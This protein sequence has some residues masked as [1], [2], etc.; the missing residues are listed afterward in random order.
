MKNLLAIEAST[1][2]CSVAL[3]CNGQVQVLNSDEP[4]AHTASL[5]AFVD[6]LLQSSAVAVPQLDAVVFSAGPGSFTGI[7]LA[8]AVAKSLAYAAGLPVIGIS[9]L[10]AMAQAFY[11]QQA[12][13]AT[14]RII[15]D[16][17]MGEF[18]SGVYRRDAQGHIVAVQQDALLTLDQL[19]ALDYND[20]LV[21]TDGSLAVQ[22]ALPDNTVIHAVQAGAEA[23]LVLADQQWQR[24]P[25]AQNSALTA[26]VNYLRGKSGWKNLEQQKR[27]PLQGA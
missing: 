15:T 14:C 1:R 22:Q 23:L 24:M 4:R 19:Q 20:M 9:S 17:R 25:P 12:Q 2:L 18:Y 10:A 16:A 13:A 7:R 6:Q 8:A 5:F 21:V 27:N 26:Q 11:Q 3:S